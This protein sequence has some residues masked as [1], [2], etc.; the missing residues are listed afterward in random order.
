M[1]VKLPPRLVWNRGDNT[2]Q[3]PGNLVYYETARLNVNPVTENQAYFAAADPASADPARNLWFCGDNYALLEMLCKVNNSQLDLI[4]IDPPYMTDTDFMSTISIGGYAQAQHINREAFCDR[5]PGGLDAYLDMLYPRLQLMH[6]ILARKGSILVH[7]DWHTSHYVRVL[8]DEVFGAQNFVNEIAWCFGGGSSSHRYFHR[9]H[10][11]IFWYAK[12]SEYTY[13]PQYR[14]YTKGTL[15]RGL[16]TVKGERYKL[17]EEG[18]LMQDWWTD[19][20]KILSPTARENLKYPTQ[21]PRELLRRLIAAI[22]KPGDKVADFFA[23]S[24]TLGEV[25]D[26]LGRSWIMCDNSKLALQTSLYR[27]ISAG[28]PPLAI[29]GTSQMPADNQ[30]GLLLLKEPEA[31]FENGEEMLLAVGIEY[32]RPAALEQ[33]IPAA[34]SGDYIEFWEI[35]PDYDQRC[36]N[37]CYQVIRPRHRFKEPIPLEVGVKVTPKAGRLLAVK[38]WDVFANQ[39]LAAVKLPD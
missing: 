38:V 22:S 21:K 12:S 31:R 1:E 25:C 33:D 37:S 7:V 5:W 17:N 24:G 20:N 3:A 2:D 16:T 14:P 35:D 9:K 4:Y 13:N 19:I 15:Q 10:D 34:Q 39:T 36:F 23:G 30:T 26:E 29:A 28:T 18:A 11:L 8:L 32:F 6:K 27:L